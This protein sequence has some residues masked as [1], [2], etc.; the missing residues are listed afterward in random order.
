MTC[1][2]AIACGK[3]L[4]SFALVGLYLGLHT[5]LKLLREK[6][7]FRKGQGSGRVIQ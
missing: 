1:Q 5:P 3:G 4:M 2:V 6:L 7:A